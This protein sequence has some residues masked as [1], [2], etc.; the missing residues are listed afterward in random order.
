MLKIRW[1]C[2]D[3]I[4]NPLLTPDGISYEKEALME[5]CKSQGGF[6]PV[7]RNSFENQTLINNKALQ[8]AIESFLEKEPWAF[9]GEDVSDYNLVIL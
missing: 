8:T 3:F 1:F 9:D 2:K 5:H 6:D 4:K 7:T